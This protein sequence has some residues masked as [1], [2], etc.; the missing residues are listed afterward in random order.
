[1]YKCIVQLKLNG[2]RVFLCYFFLYVIYS[3]PC[4]FS[5]SALLNENVQEPFKP[6]HSIVIY[7]DL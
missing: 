5:C 4:C 1:M 6:G 7:T 2:Q 3:E